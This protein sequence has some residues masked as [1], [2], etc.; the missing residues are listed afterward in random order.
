MK[1]SKLSRL[2]CDRKY[3]ECQSKL[4][5]RYLRVWPEAG[6]EAVK[7]PK[8]EDYVKNIAPELEELKKKTD[9]VFDNYLSSIVNPKI[10]H[11]LLHQLWQEVTK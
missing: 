5:A 1:R 4:E 6:L 11:R 10:Q 8:D 3:I 9:E 2:S 7:V